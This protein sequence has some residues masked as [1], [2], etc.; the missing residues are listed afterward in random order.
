MLSTPRHSALTTEDLNKLK[1]S[2]TVMST[3]SRVLDKMLDGGFRNYSV[4]EIYGPAGSGKTRLI[5]QLLLMAAITLEESIYHIDNEGNFRPS[6]VEDIAKKHKNYNKEMLNKI[7][8]SRPITH[9][10]FLALLD[11]L[12]GI[13]VKFLSIDTIITHIRMLP[14][15]DYIKSLKEILICLRNIA[16]KG[17][18][19]VFTNQVTMKES[20]VASGG[21]LIEYVIDYKLNLERVENRIKCTVDKPKPVKTEFFRI[22]SKGFIGY[23]EPLIYEDRT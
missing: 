11:F 9:E 2:I 21:K 6:I 19:V 3:G 5:H 13:K 14:S 10:Q 23:N 16:N 7:Y 17:A 8:V 12:S 20:V 22:V 1:N 18:F 15:K 4:A